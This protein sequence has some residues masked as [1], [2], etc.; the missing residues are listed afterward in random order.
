MKIIATRDLFIDGK[1]YKQG[2]EIDVEELGKFKIL[3]LNSTHCIVPLSN[4]EL[5]ELKA[6][7]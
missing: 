7:V 4:K 5:T 1:I 6:Q 3:Q 2:K